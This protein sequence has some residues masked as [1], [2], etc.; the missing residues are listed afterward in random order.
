MYYF[1][2]SD[3]PSRVAT[4]SISVILDGKR[5]LP[6]LP[7]YSA[8]AHDPILL[9]IHNFLIS[10]AKPDRVGGVPCIR[11]KFE[12][13]ISDRQVGLG[14]HGVCSITGGLSLSR[15]AK[16]ARGFATVITRG[17]EPEKRVS[18]ERVIR[19]GGIAG[20]RVLSRSIKILFSEGR[21]QRRLFRRIYPAGGPFR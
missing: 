3:E 8:I 11:P 15:F 20:R 4:T 2:D 18:V 19:R 12:G 9:S 13:N 14:S 21:R 5:R 7:R 1:A 10:S 6:Q 16:W 17:G